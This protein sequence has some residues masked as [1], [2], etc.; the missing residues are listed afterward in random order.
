MDLCDVSQYYYNL[1][2]LLHVIAVHFGQFL[3]IIPEMWYS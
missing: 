3:Y 1:N 2:R